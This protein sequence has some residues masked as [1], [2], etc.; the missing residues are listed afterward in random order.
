MI[1]LIGYIGSLAYALCGL[2]Q[3]IMSIRNGHSKGI[4][5]GYAFLSLF[6]SIFSIIYAFPRA[7]YVLLLN[8][9]ANIIVWSIILKY[10]YFERR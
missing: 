4:S 1:Q 7:D 3:A 2:P 9:G 8:F 5:R 6:G 10:S